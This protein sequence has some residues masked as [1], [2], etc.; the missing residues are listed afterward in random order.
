MDRPE[1]LAFGEISR[2]IPVATKPEVRNTSVTCAMLVAVEEFAE[3]LLAPLGAP[4][5][6]RTKIQ[7]WTEPVFKNPKGVVS[8]DRPDALIIVDNGRRQW[9]ALV[10][11]KAKN[12]SLESGQV[13]RYLDLAR[14]HGIDALVT[15]SNQFVATPTQSPCEINRTKLRKVAL[16]HWSWSYLKTEAKI[17]LSKSA[18]SDPDQAYM[19]DEYVRFLE[20]DSAGV[21]EFE[22]MGKEWVEACRLYFAKSMLQKKSPLAAAVVSNWDE[23]M[24]CTALN[25]SRQLDTNVTTVLSVKER[26]DPNKR[27]EGLLASFI[28]SGELESR[29]EVPGAASPISV[30]ADLTRRSVTVSMV[31]DAPRDR[32][33]APATVSWLLRQ[34]AKTKDERILIVAKWPGRTQDTCTELGK[35]RANVDSLL[36]DRT[37]Q[38][39]RSFEIKSVSDLGGKFTQR[40]KFV[41]ELVACVFNYYEAVGQHVVPWQAP[42]PKPKNPAQIATADEETNIGAKEATSQSSD[43]PSGSK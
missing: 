34:L 40:R 21:S 20:H 37:G 42:P 7:V 28:S 8:K 16:Y 9:R 6:K 29:L 30:E 36:I 12:V 35:V 33:R 22:Q 32:K 15:L 25:M 39:P 3:A 27:L 2:L 38:L 13:E 14:A 31:V 24:R 23:L 17:Q 5:G 41:P 19:L 18:V 1:Y 43:N 10:E 11:A 26:K 4:I